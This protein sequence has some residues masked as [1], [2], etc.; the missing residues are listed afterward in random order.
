M[1]AIKK[2]K[3]ND[4]S[5]APYTVEPKPKRKGPPMSEETKAKLK[6][7]RQD[8]KAKGL[9]T[10]IKRKNVSFKADQA[11]DKKKVSPEAVAI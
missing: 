9:P 3:T 1:P 6:A 2:E 7:L 8:R 10:R 4:G 11:T 5:A